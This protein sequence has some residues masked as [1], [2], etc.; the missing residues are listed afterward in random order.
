[1]TILDSNT[2]VNI[3][4]LHP[5]LKSWEKENTE[6]KKGSPTADSAELQVHLQFQ[7]SST[8]CCVLL[9]EIYSANK[10]ALT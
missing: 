3:L 2:A 10:S 5:P 7:H 1:M 4:L 8:C 6:T 9:L